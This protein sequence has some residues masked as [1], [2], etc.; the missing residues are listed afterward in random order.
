MTNKNVKNWLPVAVKGVLRVLGA[1]LIFVGSLAWA[2]AQ[3]SSA[4]YK[5]VDFLNSEATLTTS[6]A[7]YKL[8]DSVDYYGG[9]TKT[10][11]SQIQQCT[12]DYAVLSACRQTAG[13]PPPPPPVPVPT[14]TPEIGGSGGDHP[15]H[16]DCNSVD[17]INNPPATPPVEQPPVKPP[18]KIPNI[19]EPVPGPVV[20]AVPVV[21]PVVNKPVPV[22]TTT[23]VPT[24]PAGSPI[25]IKSGPAVAISVNPQALKP[26]ASPLCE[27][28]ACSETNLL[29]PSAASKL[30][31]KVPAGP[32]CPLYLFGGY[33]FNLSCSDSTLVLIA[34]ALS[35]LGL[36]GI[37]F[38]LDRVVAEAVQKRRKVRS[39]KK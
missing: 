12:G 11:T 36:S 13:T 39:K 2:S 18:F 21:K 31:S 25:L 8:S 28:L 24:I 37:T 33:Q 22:S 1:G 14:P 15:S 9:I 32:V 38:R 5:A 23:P 27:D 3:S 4:S 29:R 17:C 19:T 16:T 20:P 26:A 34:V 35:V 10:A 6:S 7:S 30:L